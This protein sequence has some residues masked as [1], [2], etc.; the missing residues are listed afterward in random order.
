MQQ[1]K[2]YGKI[3]LVYKKNMDSSD[4]IK[5]QYFIFSIV[6]SVILSLLI[7]FLMVDFLKGSFFYG[8]PFDLTDAS[9]IASFFYRVLN[10]LA[11]SVVL[12]VPLYY[13]FW[14]LANKLRY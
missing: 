3:L 14:W 5:K 11:Y 9:D 10:S 2:K 7:N 12:V 8:F 6:V 13:G 4:P 1:V